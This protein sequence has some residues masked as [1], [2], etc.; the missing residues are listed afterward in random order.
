MPD[1]YSYKKIIEKKIISAVE[2]VLHT[3][4]LSATKLKA[5]EIN[6]VYKVITTQGEYVARVFRYK[7]WPEA[8]KLEWIEKQLLKH[9]VLHAKIIYCTRNKDHFPNGFMLSEFVRG[10]SGTDAVKQKLLSET[11]LYEKLGKLARLIHGI[12][13]QRHGLINSGKGQFTNYLDMPLTDAKRLLNLL[14]KKGA[15]KQDPYEQVKKI[16]E[17]IINK[18]KQHITPVLLH[19]DMSETNIIVT[20]N[21]NIILIDWDNARAGFWLSDFIELSRR[22]LAEKSWSA[23]PLRMKKARNAF[24]K[25][26]GKTPFTNRQ[27]L[28]LEKTLLLIRYIW[29]M[30]YYFFDNKNPKNFNAIK[31]A[32]YKLLKN[33]Y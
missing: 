5:G 33:K 18:Y 23:N 25:G 2:N 27:L 32:F 1:I 7:N 14:T 24:F 6:H 26:Y 15:L 10:T 11:E 31:R 9:R 22:H 3:K 12:A 19:G 30:N 29:Q 4:V 21:K 16:V 8:N 20:P 13:V 17:T 28:T